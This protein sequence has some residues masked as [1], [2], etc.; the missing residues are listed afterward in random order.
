MKKYLT[1]VNKLPRLEGRKVVADTEGSGLKYMEDK[2]FLLGIKTVDDNKNYAV[3]W[4]PSLVEYMN[5]EFPQAEKIIGHNLKYDTHMFMQGGMNKY[6]LLKLKP[7]DTMLAESLIDAHQPSYS[8]DNLGKAHLGKGKDSQ[9]MYDWLA[10]IFGGKADRSQMNNFGALALMWNENP[11]KYAPNV[12]PYLFG[13]LDTTAGLEAKRTHIITNEELDGV[14]SLEMDSLLSLVAV[15]RAGIP[16]DRKALDAAIVRFKELYRESVIKTTAMVGRE[17]NVLSSPALIM[18]FNMLGIPVPYG[19]AG[20]V[21]FKKEL[22]E[23]IDHPFAAQIIY[24]R[25]M[26]KADNT[27]GTGFLSKIGPDG[28]VHTQFNQ[29]RQDEYGTVTG[30][31]SSSDPN[32]QQIPKRNAEMAKHLRSVFVAPKGHMWINADWSQFEFRVFAHY[33]NDEA[34]L[35]VYADDPDVDYHQALTDIINLVYLGR[36]KVKRINLG[37]VFGMGEGKLA[38]ECKL[39]YT[40]TTFKNGKKGLVAGPEAKGIFSDYHERFPGAKAVLTRATALAKARGYVK[41]ISGRR[42]R[43]PEPQY[44][45]KAGGSV[46]Q[47]TSADIMKSKKNELVRKYYGT[48]TDLILLVHDEFNLTAP[49]DIAKQVA[50]EVKDILQD[51]PQLRVPVRAK[52]GVGPNWYQAGEAQE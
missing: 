6:L 10:S 35:K 21:S 15:E 28:R 51:V 23:L 42:I 8:L 16:V 25:S 7:H 4:T 45:Y 40:I 11:K 9:P 26:R 14:F 29:L 17:T 41:T 43:F 18:A 30:R 48:D 52:V 44:T 39:P 37:L 47:G 3:H 22:L 12:V 31:L 27:F 1:P 49:K 46:F 32:M 50:G 13:D 36:D 2:P 5:R 24:E 38:K 33:T 34:L 19:D 20:R